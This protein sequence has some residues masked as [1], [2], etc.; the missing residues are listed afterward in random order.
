MKTFIRE[1]AFDLGF[2]A[3]GFALPEIGKA[4]RERLREYVENREYGD[5]AWMA[6]NVDVRADPKVLWP[7]AESVI[8]LGL[9]YGPPKDAPAGE[10]GNITGNSAYISVYARNRDYHDIVKKRLKRLARRIADRYGGGF[11][12]FVDTAPVLEKA[13]AAKSGIGWMGK[14]TNIVSRQFGTWLFLGEIFTTLEIPPDEPEKNRCGSCMKCVRA[15]PAGAIIKPYRLNPRRCLSYFTIEHKGLIPPA[16]HARM[17]NRVYGCDECLSVCPWNRFAR[18]TREPGLVPRTDLIAPG[19][20]DLAGLDDAEFRRFFSG[21]GIKR[22]GHQR[23][24]RN[25]GIAMGNMK[26]IF[27]EGSN[28]G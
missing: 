27:G 16:F 2:D 28:N 17:G 1:Q 5:M 12:V 19:L 4:D 20:P 11:R 15:C 7:E 21:S 25:V 22:I 23:F 18:E 10:R 9:N 14:H 24:N 8:V 6:R 3:A 26:T 13:L